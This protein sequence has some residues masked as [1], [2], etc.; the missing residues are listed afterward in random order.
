MAALNTD[1]IAVAARS[2]GCVE[3]H[4]PAGGPRRRIVLT[5]EAAQRVGTVLANAGFDALGYDPGF[6]RAS[7]VRLRPYDANGDAMLELTFE[8]FG[9]PAVF[10]LGPTVLIALAQ[11]A[12]AALEFSTPA[13]EP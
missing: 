11:A 8:E 13:G 5:A 1:D 3:L 6:L 4:L 10:R 12:Q 9:G 7:A 2:D